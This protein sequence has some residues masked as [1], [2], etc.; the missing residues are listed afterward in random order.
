LYAY[1]DAS[2][3]RDGKLRVEANIPLRL[4]GNVDGKISAIDSKRLLEPL[5]LAAREALDYM[6]NR[7]YGTSVSVSCEIPVGAGLGSSAATTVAIIAAVSRASGTLLEKKE[8]FEIAF[9]PESYLHG[10][11]SGVDQATCTYGGIIRFSK[12]DKVKE[13]GLKT[14][15]RLVVCDTGIH[16]S[17]KGLVGAVV[18]RSKVQSRLFHGHV[19]EVSTISESAVKALKAGDDEELGALMNRNQELLEQIGVSHPKLNHLVNVAR[20]SGAVGAKLT[21]AGGGGCMIALCKDERGMVRVVRE[22]RRQGG[23]PYRTSLDRLGVQSEA[24]GTGLK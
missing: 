24:K 20:R 1:A 2:C 10:K 8:I 21:G 22:L 4:L 9:G 5:R 11:P 19:K 16:R 3:T 13:L 15:P 18:K 14:M 6:G 12:P 17:T 23:T 7:S